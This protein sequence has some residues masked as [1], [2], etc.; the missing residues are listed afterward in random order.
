M[1][2]FQESGDRPCL[3]LHPPGMLFSPR[4]HNVGSLAES[5]SCQEEEDGQ[6]DSPVEGHNLEVRLSLLFPLTRMQPCDQLK[7]WT[8]EKVSFMLGNL[9]FC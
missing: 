1:L 6:R 9:R 2:Q 7:P 3:R 8:C 5:H 4:W